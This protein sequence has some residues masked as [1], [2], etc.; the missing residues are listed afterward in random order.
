MVEFSKAR[1][2]LRFLVTLLYVVLYHTNIMGSVL[3][4]CCAVIVLV[5]FPDWYVK[6]AKDFL[7]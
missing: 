5:N 7:L 6:L 4:A 2:L 3:C 1:L